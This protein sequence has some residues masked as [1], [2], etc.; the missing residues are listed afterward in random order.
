MEYFL[1]VTDFAAILIITIFKVHSYHTKQEFNT[2]SN[3]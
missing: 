3:K 1:M 2:F